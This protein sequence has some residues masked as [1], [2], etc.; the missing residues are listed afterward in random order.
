MWGGELILNAFKSGLF[1]LKSTKITRLKILIPKLML[2][3]L[4]IA[5][6][7]VKAGNNSKSLLNKIREMFILY[8]IQNKLL[9]KYVTI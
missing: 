5:P 3:R 4:P 9:K 6:A 7:Q 2:Q 8:I 1:L